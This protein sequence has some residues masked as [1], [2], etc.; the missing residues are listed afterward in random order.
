M[1][2][3]EIKLPSSLFQS[4]YIDF[5]NDEKQIYYNE[6]RDKFLKHITS[7][8]RRKRRRK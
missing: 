4:K 3:D 7:K 1:S 5:M 8:P 6:Q 2:K